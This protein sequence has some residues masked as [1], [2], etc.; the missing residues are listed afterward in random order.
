MAAARPDDGNLHSP[1]D[2]ARATAPFPPR[3]PRAAAARTRRGEE[4]ERDA[5]C[6]RSHHWTDGWVDFP[7]AGASQS[8]A[9]DREAPHRRRV[10]EA[11]SSKT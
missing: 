8:H 9:R 11:P 3:P 1:R 10:P 6:P 5:A 7:S 2:V 4:T